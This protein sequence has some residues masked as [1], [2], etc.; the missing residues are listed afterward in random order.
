MIVSEYTGVVITDP[1]VPTVYRDS[2]I[3]DRFWGLFDFVGG[4]SYSGPSGVIPIGT[5]I[6]DMQYDTPVATAVTELS[7]VDGGLELQRGTDRLRLGDNW[8]LPSNCEH[9]AI[10]MWVNL[11]GSGYETGGTG[12]KPYSIAG[13]KRESSNAYQWLVN[14]FASRADGTIQTL[15]FIANDKSVNIPYPGDG[16]HA[17]HLEYEILGSDH[18]TRFYIDGELVASSAPTSQ[19]YVTP[20]STDFPAVGQFTSS[21]NQTVKGVVPR[22]WGARLDV[23]GRSI[24]ELINDD[25][26]NQQRLS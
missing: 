2:L 17:L 9:W 6:R 21:F 5:E 18:V 11:D 16:L 1:S 10:G 4:Y 25:M 24:A 3:D 15:Q 23:A 26:R 7:K 12:N 20:E 14:V 8:R 19:S 22:L 13:F